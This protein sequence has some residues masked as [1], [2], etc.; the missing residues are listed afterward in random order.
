MC[1]SATSC[2]L[3]FKCLCWLNLSDG[4]Y[5][6][7]VLLKCF[8]AFQLLRET[9]STF[10]FVSET[11]L[12]FGMNYALTAMFLFWIRLVVSFDR[13]VRF[14]FTFRM[15]TVNHSKWILL[16]WGNLRVSIPM[17]KYFG[18]ILIRIKG[19]YLSKNWFCSYLLWKC[20]AY[21]FAWL[22]K[23]KGLWKILFA[24][25][26]LLIIQFSIYKLLSLLNFTRWFHTYLFNLKFSILFVYFIRFLWHNQ[27]LPKISILQLN[28]SPSKRTELLHFISL[29]SL[30][31]RRLNFWGN[32]LIYE[33]GF[34]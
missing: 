10:V 32:F 1:I 24:V 25:V 30:C 11:S 12:Y 27:L 26:I 18:W 5:F 15:G 33:K 9:T 3:H 34:G 19:L 21:R 4:L 22:F 16:I 14:R 7:K 13:F 8:A 2:S 23:R 28:I 29:L 20:F 31:L 6:L 17:F